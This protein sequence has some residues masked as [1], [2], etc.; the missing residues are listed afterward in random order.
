[1]ALKLDSELAKIVAIMR[2]VTAEHDL[3]INPDDSLTGCRRRDLRKAGFLTPTE[4]H[5]CAR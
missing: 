5:A 4:Q 1:M 3:Y 2:T